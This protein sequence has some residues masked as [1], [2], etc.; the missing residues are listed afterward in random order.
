[1]QEILDSSVRRRISALTIY[2]GVAT[3]Q[4][5]SPAAE[6]TLA[7]SF[8]S[9]FYPFSLLHA[10]FDL[11]PY[12]Y[13]RFAIDEIARS[14]SFFFFINNF[15]QFFSIIFRHFFFPIHF[16]N[17]RQPGKKIWAIG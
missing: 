10:L 8:L 2:K 16:S 5:H 7:T 6:C 1:M 9:T 17:R 3:G 4:N 12:V 15:L 13:D 11:H 14:I